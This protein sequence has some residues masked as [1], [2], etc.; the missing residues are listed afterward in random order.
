M[1]KKYFEELKPKLVYVFRINDGAHKGCLKIGEATMD[2]D[3]DEIDICAIQPNASILNKA[4]LARIDQ[5]TATAGIVYDLLYTE[6]A[7]FRKG[8]R[9]IGFNDKDV[10]E[11]LRRSGI[12][13]KEFPGL[14]KGGK[15]GTLPTSKP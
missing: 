13:R 12:K 7:V 11:V 5:Y 9:T 10:H 4:A 14:D 15:D 3:I 2:V 6:S 1:Q 8:T